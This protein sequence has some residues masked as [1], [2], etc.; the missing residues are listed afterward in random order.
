MTRLYTVAGAVL[1]LGT[2]VALAQQTPAAKS[3]TATAPA[4]T[5]ADAT[6]PTLTEQQAKSWIDKPVY[7]S[8]GKKIG[9]IV[10]FR[11]G[12]DNVVQE[13]H[14]DIGGLF[15]MGE[16]RVKV[17]PQQFKLQNDRA[18]LNVTEAQAKDLPKVGS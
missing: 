9:E 3:E 10:E 16:T 1:L 15:G 2:S 6:K 5:T 17:M 14:A 18:V 11:R 8:D 4:K 7:S 12:A 13:M